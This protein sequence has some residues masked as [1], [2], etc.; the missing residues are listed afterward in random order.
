[1]STPRLTIGLPVYNGEAYLAE[2]LESLLAQDYD[3]FELVVSDNASTDSTVAIVE[4]FAERDPRVRLVRNDRNMG[5][6]YNYNRLV[7]DSRAELFKWAGYDDLLEP[8]N[9]SSCVAALDA[10]PDAVLAFA[11]ATIIDGV[12]D[13]VREYNERLEIT[14]RAPWRR[15]ASFAWRFSLCNAAFGVMRRE[16][17]TRTGL[18]RPYI[19]S[20]VTFLAEM[21]A[22]GTFDLVDRRLFRRRVH[23]S[24]SRQ[25]RTSAAEI[26][27]WFDPATKGSP[28]F[29]RLRLLGR[30]TRAL[31]RTTGSLPDDL[32]S[33]AA[34]AVAYSA[35]RARISAGRLRARVQGRMLTPPELIH[36]VDGSSS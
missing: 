11:Q 21:A 19:S 26:A 16:P 34:F 10:N 6:A 2:T 36:Q 8:E 20:D 12:G 23:E 3:D 22:M 15:V 24:S 5:A 9:V 4:S 18:I 31:S 14:A 13:E 7:T 17:M 27:T 35:R 29:I 28:T 30:T 33:G 1:M 32:S 25:G